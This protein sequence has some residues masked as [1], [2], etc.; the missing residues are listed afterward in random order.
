[1]PVVVTVAPTF[2]LLT[3]CPAPVTGG[4]ARLSR[5]LIGECS[6]QT[7]HFRRSSVRQLFESAEADETYFA[8]RRST[9][10]LEQLQTPLEGPPRLDFWPLGISDEWTDAGQLQT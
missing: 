1:M 7:G 6:A 10:A 2:N 9:G 8:W 5:R 4:D 3:G